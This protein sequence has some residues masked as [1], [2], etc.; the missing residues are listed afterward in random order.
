MDKRR[1]ILDAFDA[2]LDLAADDREVFLR[3]RFGDDAEAIASVRALIAADALAPATLPTELRPTELRSAELPG[4]GEG[5][6]LIAPARIGAYRLDALLGAGGMGEVWCGVR[7]DG[8]F[9]QQVAIKLMRPSRYA[10]EALTYFDTERRALA[11]L[12]H[13]HI[14]RLFDGGVTDAGLPWFIM[15]RVD[16]LPLHAYAGQWVLSR[17]DRLRLMAGIAEAVQY[18]HQQLVVHADLKPSNILIRPD[19]TPCLVDFGIASLAAAAAEQADG[20]AFPSTPA[21]ASPQRLS[22]GAPTPSDDIFSLGLLL[23]GLAGGTWPE[24]PV[25]TPAATGDA[26]IDGI[27]AR[28]CAAEP[29]D[30]YAT[31][32]AFAADVRAV[33]DHR[34]TSG[35]RGDWRAEGR[36]YVRRHP[37]A[38]TAGIAAIVAT[39]AALGLISGLYLRAEHERERA[40]RRFDDVRSLA[41]YMLG[42]FHDELVKLPGS[43][44]LRERNATVGWQYLTRLS[45]DDNVPPDVLRDIAVGYGR[46]G[47][48][49]ATSSSN[50]NGHVNQGDQA[51]QKSEKLLRDLVK[52]YPGRD[53]YRRELARTLTWRSGVIL[54]AHNDPKGAMAAIQEAFAL[55]DDVLKRNPNDLE[56]AYGRWNAMIGLADIYYGQDNMPGVKALMAEAQTRFAHIGVT[57][58]YQSLSVLLQAATENYLGDSNYYTVSPQAGVDH[59]LRA[60]ALTAQGRADGV[61]DMRIPMRQAYYDYQLSSSYE[62]M[63]KPKL[64]LQWADKGAA[65]A[66]DLNQFDGSTG[67]THIRDIL[68]LHRATALANLGRSAE[69]VA[70]AESS[71]ERRRATL[72]LHPEDADNRLNLGTGLHTLSNFYVTAKM[73][74]KACAAARESLATFDY[75]AHHGGVPARYQR[76]DVTP[77]QQFTATCG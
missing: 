69:A 23:H 56:A 49:Q 75:I 3:E 59:Y 28:A 60:E 66:A 48:A 38:V 67:T 35:Q 15:E 36:L 71:V 16:G 51:L 29:A 2:A 54:G 46:L 8:L 12:A 45:Q 70:E 21:Y 42:D 17:N 14:A 68:S 32:D 7:D 34:A 33:L 77:L 30:R 39:V 76:S 10:S 52:A 62:E 4:G 72:R 58:K 5:T 37:R 40:Q 11:R 47:N 43:T 18:A 13:P 57:P 19:G 73:P 6:V 63:E 64:A 25:H 22:G 20:N 44:A 41:G 1:A 26:I 50:G 61:M 24:R 65:I 9:D 53:D 31:A 27:I 55:F 74:A